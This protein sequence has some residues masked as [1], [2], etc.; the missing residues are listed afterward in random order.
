MNNEINSQFLSGLKK[1]VASKI[2][3]KKIIV[4]GSSSGG[5]KVIEKIVTSLPKKLDVGIVIVQHMPP[6]FTATFARRISRHSN[7]NVQEAKSGDFLRPGLV[8][9]APGGCNLKAQKEET[10]LDE[11]PAIAVKLVKKPKTILKP[12]IDIMMESVVKIL[13]EK[14]IGIIL[15]GMGEDGV[16][17]MKTIKSMGGV[18]IVQKENTADIPGLPHKIIENK[19]SDYILTPSEIVSKIVEIGGQY[20]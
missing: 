3:P 18:T 11:K 13:G 10:I 20:K 9:V 1:E 19:L 15:S 16:L 5:P 4:I 17:G 12:S 7:I 8:L 2:I 14:T 6:V